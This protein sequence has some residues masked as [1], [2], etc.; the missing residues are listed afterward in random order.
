MRSRNYEPKSISIDW[1]AR[2]VGKAIDAGPD[3]PI[4]GVRLFGCIIDAAL[5]AAPPRFPY[6]VR[7]EEAC[8]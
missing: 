4:S 5:R 6:P 7:L 2:R 1:I 3:V 8:G